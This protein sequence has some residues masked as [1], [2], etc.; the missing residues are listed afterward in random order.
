MPHINLKHEP[1]E[2]TQDEILSYLRAF[3][4]ADVQRALKSWRV[5]ESKQRRADGWVPF[6]GRIEDIPEG[7]EWRQAGT[8]L[9]IRSPDHQQRKAEALAAQPTTAAPKRADLS[10]MPVSDLKCPKCTDKMFKEGICPSCEDGRKG[11]RVRLLCGNCDF[12]ILL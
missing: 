3:N 8:R 7:T 5:A 12:L 9:Q 4:F 6:V 2:R 11:F 10:T 1:N